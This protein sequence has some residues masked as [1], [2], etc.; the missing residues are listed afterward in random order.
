MTEKIGRQIRML[1][2]RAYRHGKISKASL[3]AIVQATR[4]PA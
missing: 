1:A 2:Y 3:D 4:V